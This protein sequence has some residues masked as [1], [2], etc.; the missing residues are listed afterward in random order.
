MYLYLYFSAT[1]GWVFLSVWSRILWLWSRPPLTPF[2]WHFCNLLLVH[3]LFTA[4]F[5][6]GPWVVAFFYGNC[7][8]CVRVESPTCPTGPPS[9]ALKFW[10]MIYVPLCESAQPTWRKTEYLLWAGELMKLVIIWILTVYRDK[11]FSW[12]NVLCIDIFS[13]IY[14][15]VNLAIIPGFI[16]EMPAS[17]YGHLFLFSIHANRVPTTTEPRLMKITYNPINV[18]LSRSHSRAHSFIQSLSQSY[19]Q[20]VIWLAAFVLT[21]LFGPGICDYAA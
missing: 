20:S 3:Y 4:N 1:F 18:K 19:C 17:R 5:I 11:R 16:M 2:S 6:F 14:L 7:M 13:E 9:Y 12:N 21:V 15:P 8:G 10:K